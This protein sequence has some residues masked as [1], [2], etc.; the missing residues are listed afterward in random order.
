[1]RVPFVDSHVHF[2]D[3]ARLRY[4]YLGGL[5]SISA[6]HDPATLAAEAGPDLPARCVFVQAECDRTQWLDEVRWVA[7]LAVADPRIAA[8]VAHA[9]VDVPASLPRVLDAL[10][11][12][13]LVRGVRHLIQD[14]SDP[15]FCLREE[16]VAG[17]RAVGERNLVFDLCC[18]HQQ[19]GAVL[20]LV[21]L[22]PGTSFVLDHAGKPAVGRRE[23]EPWA[24]RMRDLAARP[25]VVC[26]L[27]G[28]VTETAPLAP[29]I[30]TLRPYVTT[31]QE[32]FGPQR[33][34]FG[35]DWPIAKLA[36]GYREWLDLATGLLSSLS[37]PDLTAVFHDNAVRTYR[38]A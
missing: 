16:F 9:S 14:E 7:E 8:I 20:E 15:D 36:A 13:P 28:L 2:W 5:P 19:L 29:T 17:V 23:M 10:Q 4:G 1:V 33:L 25:N 34:L 35:S 38:L 27:S 31:L 26:K 18:R 6:R 24:S 22:C 11:R 30:E 21:R 32:T 12:E 3:P 37:T